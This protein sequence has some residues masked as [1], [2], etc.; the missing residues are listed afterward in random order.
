MSALRQDDLDTRHEPRWA[1]R[2]PLTVRLPDA[3][4]RDATIEELSASGCRV[5]LATRACLGDRLRLHVDGFTSFN[6]TLIWND[7]AQCGLQFE[8][9]LHIAVVD[10]LVRRGQLPAA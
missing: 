5:R 4:R 1:L 8:R 6:G 7:G 2:L 9:P 10:H 3:T